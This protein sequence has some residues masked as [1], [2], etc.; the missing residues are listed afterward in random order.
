MLAA[1]AA[2]VV[3]MDL[4]LVG[5]RLDL[6]DI[7]FVAASVAQVTTEPGRLVAEIGARDRHRAPAGPRGASQPRQLFDELDGNAVGIGQVEAAHGRGDLHESDAT[8]SGADADAVANRS[9]KSS[10]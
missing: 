9:A 2:P 4:P 8:A 7:D 6:L 10:T 3:D 5:E 1:A